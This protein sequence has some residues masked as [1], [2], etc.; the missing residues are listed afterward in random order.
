MKFADIKSLDEKQIDAKVTELRRELFE[1]RMQ[2]S[3]SGSEKPHK[4]R[5][6]KK[7]IARLLTAKSNK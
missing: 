4:F 3:T 6:L 1:L 7:D 2:K 5:E